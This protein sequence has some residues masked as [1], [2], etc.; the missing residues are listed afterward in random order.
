MVIGFFGSFTVG[1]AQPAIMVLFSDVMNAAG[2]LGGT[3]AQLEKTFDRIVIKMMVVGGIAFVGGWLGEAGWSVSGLR[4]SAKWRQ[5]YLKAILRQDVAWYDTSNPSELSSRIAESTQ[6]VSE[7]ISSKLALGTRYLGQGVCGLGVAFYYSWDLSLVLLALSPIVMF[8]TWFMT[9]ATTDA[10]RDTADAYAAAG[11]VAGETI[12]ALRT[13]ASLTAE[14]SQAAKYGASLEQAR[15]AGVRKSYRVGFANGLLFASGNTMAA[16]GFI[17]GAYR[18]ARELRDTTVL[19]ANGSSVNCQSFWLGPGPNPAG[20]CNFSAGNVIVALF[21]LQMGA[22]G[23]GLLEPS[24]SALATARKAAHSIMAIMDRHPLIDAFSTKGLKPDKS[25]L[26][27]ELVFEDVE[28]AYPS[29]L[30]NPV[31]QGYNLIVP[32]GQ[33][34]ALVGASGSGKSTAIQLVERFYDPTAGRVTLDGVDLRDLNVT[35]LRSQIGLVGQEPV[36]FG[37]TI[38]ENIAYGKDGATMDEIITAAKM[39]N[40]HDFISDFPDGYDTDVGEKGGQLSGGQKQ[41]VAIARAMLKNPKILLLDEATSALDTESERVVQAALDSLIHTTKRTTIVIAHRLSTIRDADKICVVDQGRIVEQGTHDQLLAKGPEGFYFK[42]YQKGETAATDDV[43]KRKVSRGVSNHDPR[44]SIHIDVKD[45]KVHEEVPHEETKE[46][47][48]AKLK[49]KKAEEAAE[50]KRNSKNVSRV[51]SMY[52]T[53]DR[54]YFLLGSIGAFMVG[55]ANP[56]IGIVFVKSLFLFY[57]DDPE[58]MERDAV[59]WSL[60]MLAISLA[61]VLGDTCRYWGF[62]VPGEKLTV[63]L[64]QMYYDAIVRQEIGWHDLPEH[65]SGL[66]CAGLASEVNTIQAL[67]G[68]GMGKNILML[69]TLLCA[70]SFAL[71]WGYWAIFL[72]ALGTVPLMMSG[73]MIELAM[74]SGGAAAGDPMAALG[75]EAGKIVGEVVSSIRTIM[76]FTREKRFADRF[77]EVTSAAVKNSTCT[78]AAKGFFSGYSQLAMFSS[79]ALLYWYGGK[80][81]AKGNADFESMFIPIFCMFMLGAGMGQAA[82]GATDAT[83]AAKAAKNV[84]ELIDRKSK[85]DYANTYGQKPAKVRG[86]IVFENVQFAYPTRPDNPVAQG[87]NLRIPAGHT[88]ALVGAS[89]SGKST[90]IQLLE[91]FYDPDAGRVTLD[92]VDLRELNVNWLRSHIGLVGQEPVLFSGTIAENIANG[93]PGATREEII[94]AAKMAN[95]HDFISDFPKGYDTD[96]G[97]GGG[98]LSGGQKQRVA[99][100]RAMIK[101]PT[102][103]LL[104]E[105]TSALDT[106]S[107]RIVQAALDDLMHK[108]RRTTIVVAHRLSTIRDADKICVVKEGKIVEEGKHDELMANKEGFYYKLNGGKK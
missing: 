77:I 5:F 85:I 3:G 68:E 31:A 94:E 53:R 50:K 20:E 40:A 4:Q 69:M 61:Q 25:E 74:I 12:S 84:F 1:A 88:V 16:V 89:G 100:A 82:N 96:V 87:Y 10:A 107:E 36:L 41:R 108:T 62:A 79:F 52:E 18:M 39:S 78:T 66:L 98:Q 65:S 34:V 28:F 83:K 54:P 95:A 47:L 14:P 9:K 76:S 80:Q 93:K 55:G 21:A 72:L 42:L 30:D 29:R 56:A 105:A 101:N 49:K 19:L 92:G 103:L 63:K 15:K 2:G 27:G 35:W 46:E 32:A 45:G 51:W 81:I 7:G 11:G 86:E 24:I 37:G 57:K 106:E 22:Q 58:V 23:L 99:I 8:G 59:R 102:V 75:P 48:E 73:M 104:D 33:T 97:D 71:I 60:I 64:R 67:S 91:R 44:G 26:R 43:P 38:A 17:Y 13:V 70:V 90:A 6:A